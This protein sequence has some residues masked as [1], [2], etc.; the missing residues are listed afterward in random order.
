MTLI[1]RGLVA[2][3]PQNPFRDAESL[4]AWS[5]GGLAIEGS[6]I[7]AVGNFTD[8]AG[9]FPGNSV[10]DC[11]E[12]ILLPGLVDSHV[13]YPQTR[14]IGAMGYTLL[15]W[16]EKR[17]L[18]LEAQLSDNKLAR[19]RAREFVRLLLRNGTTTALVFGSHFQA[20][21]ASLFGAA[22]DLGLRIIAG[23]VCSD[24]ML[25]PELHTTPQRTYA[26]QKMLIQRF[27][28]RGKL[29]YAVT[30]RFS[31]SASEGLLEV[32]QTL[33][34]E[35]P[36][37]HFTTHINEHTD[38]IRTVA[39]L[40]P[41][42]HH[43]LHTYDRFNLV[44]ERSVFAH[45]VHPTEPELARLAG[46]RAAVAHCPSSNAFIG[47]GIFPMKQHLRHGV[48]FALGSDVGGGTGFCLLKE[49]LAA[50]MAQRYAQDGVNLTP[51]HLLYLATQA[52]A[53]IL[54]LGQEIGTFTPGKAADV[55][56]IKPEAGSTLEVHF[57]HLDSVDQLLGSLFTLHGEASVAKVWL[58]G[59]EA[60]LD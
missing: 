12:G 43:Y 40:F 35:H 15:D 59:Q 37:L 23:Q 31:L 29:R 22:E 27:H 50:Y 14:V 47:S 1:L 33:F 26:E 32:C 39:E 41:W 36:D 21:T 4:Q 56:W 54:G 8:L 45:N 28:G 48:R 18:P 13:H 38:E 2:H 3:A 30:P 46:A 7:V 58:D 17:T 9:Q 44:S 51:A 19:L 42:S 49:G 55:L 20:A 52:G 11:R 34:Q 60:P 10:Q 57:R 24:R 16:L 53:N 25:R 6:R 5:D